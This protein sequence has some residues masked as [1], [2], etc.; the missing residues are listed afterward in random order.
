MT[1]SVSEPVNP[2]NWWNLPGK[3][4]IESAGRRGSAVNA[5]S[6]AGR[7]RWPESLNASLAARMDA[8]RASLATSGSEK[9]HGSGAD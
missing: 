9:K 6:A 2:L 8:V 1:D 4:A 3:P 7:S 5:A